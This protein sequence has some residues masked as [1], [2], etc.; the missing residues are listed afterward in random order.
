MCMVTNY[1]DDAFLLKKI[2]SHVVILVNVPYNMNV[3]TLL[4]V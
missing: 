1:C 2:V 4:P 3:V